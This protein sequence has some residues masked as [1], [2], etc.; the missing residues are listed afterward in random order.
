M[1]LTISSITQEAE[2]THRS[3][4][5]LPFTAYINSKLVREKNSCE[6][7]DSLVVMGTPEMHFFVNNHPLW[8]GLW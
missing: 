2:E 8:G 4:N 3:H 6:V 1:K 5:V 7:V